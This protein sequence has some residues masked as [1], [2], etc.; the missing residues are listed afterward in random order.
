MCLVGSTGR[1]FRRIGCGG[2]GRNAELQK[3]SRGLAREAGYTAV[4]GN[5]GRWNGS[6]DEGH[7]GSPFGS[8]FV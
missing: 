7:P 2:E 6:G 8:Y 3:M 4:V 1:T 5:D